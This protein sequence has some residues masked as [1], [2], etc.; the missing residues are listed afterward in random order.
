MHN[1]IAVAVLDCADYLLE[2]ATCLILGQAWGAFVLGHSVDVLQ[3]VPTQGQ[4]QHQVHPLQCVKYVIQLDL[5]GGEKGWLKVMMK[6]GADGVYCLT[7][8]CLT[9][10]DTVVYTVNL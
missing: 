3:Q 6:L 10:L 2:D 7:T 8:M 5:D 1:V 9:M 4:L